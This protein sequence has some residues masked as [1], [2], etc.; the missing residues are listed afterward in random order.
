MIQSKRINGINIKY[1]I[2]D[3]GGTSNDQDYIQIRV[4]PDRGH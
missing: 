1:C 3:R 4:M 2:A